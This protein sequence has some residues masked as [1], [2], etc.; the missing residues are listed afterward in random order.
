[1]LIESVWDELNTGE[2]D[3]N[4]ED[5]LDRE[6]DFYIVSRFMLEFNRCSQKSKDEFDY[7]HISKCFDESIFHYLFKLIN[8]KISTSYP[9]KKEWDILDKAVRFLKELVKKIPTIE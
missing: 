4:S 1:M 7:S 3:P 5:I 2:R 9:A 8:P 6:R